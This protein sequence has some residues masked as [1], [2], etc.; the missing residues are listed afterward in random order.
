MAKESKDKNGMERLPIQIFPRI[1]ASPD[2]GQEIDDSNISSEEADRES[3]E[4]LMLPPTVSTYSDRVR[5]VPPPPDLET[6]RHDLNFAL[7][8]AKNALQ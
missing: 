3:E 4:P 5:Y 1:C 7:A 6:L 2:L 8:D